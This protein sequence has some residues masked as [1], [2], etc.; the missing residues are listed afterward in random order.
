MEISGMDIRYR[1]QSIIV[2]GRWRVRRREWDAFIHIFR[3]IVG[4]GLFLHDS[5]R[6]GVKCTEDRIPMLLIEVIDE[7]VHKLRSRWAP[8]FGI[9][10]LARSNE[11]SSGIHLVSTFNLK[12]V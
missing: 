8:E 10:L 1:R 7:I 11:I 3:N 12:Q 5:C 4:D 2:S 6:E 9:E